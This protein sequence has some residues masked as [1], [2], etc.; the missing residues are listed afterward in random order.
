MKRVLPLP[1]AAARH[2]ERTAVWCAARLSLRSCYIAL[3][4]T[5]SLL[6]LLLPLLG[7]SMI[8]SYENALET[9]HS[10]MVVKVNRA[11]PIRID[12]THDHSR[13]VMK[14]MIPS[15][16]KYYRWISVIRPRRT[17]GDR[18]SNTITGSLPKGREG[19]QTI[20][21]FPKP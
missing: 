3:V 14:Q 18:M 21:L 19:L 13:K 5:S 10:Q 11:M 6:L 17:A 15:H 4:L 20:M 16:V 12:T 9:D 7:C 8:S 2:S 1:T